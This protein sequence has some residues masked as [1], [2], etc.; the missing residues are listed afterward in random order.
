M[1]DPTISQR[2]LNRIHVL[3]NVIEGKVSLSEAAQVL[4]VSYRHAKRLKK[5]AADGGL[6]GILHGNRER[7]PANKTDPVMRER[8]I[9]LSDERYS[10]FNDSH[11]TEML[12]E[13]EGIVISRETVRVIRREAGIKPK[14]K[15]RARKHRKRRPR[16]AAEGMMMLW[17]GSPHAW[18]GKDCESCCLMAAMDDATGQALSLFFSEKESSW[19]YFKLLERIVSRYGIPGSVYQDRHSALVR[20]DDFMSLEEQFAGRQDPTQVGA[21]LLS[22]GIEPIVALSPQAKGRIERLFKTLQDRLV[23]CLE[24]EGIKDMGEANIYLEERFMDEYNARFQVEPEDVV[25]VWRKP[26]TNLDLARVLSFRYEATVGNDNA[27]RFSG[28][29]ID[30]PPGKWQR[31][32]AGVRVELRQLLDG[33]WRVYYKDQVIAEA[34]STEIAEPIRAKRRRKGV[35]AAHDSFWVYIGSAPVQVAERVLASR[36]PDPSSDGGSPAYQAAG[37]MRR[38]GPGRTIGATRIA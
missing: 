4:G 38:A 37:R 10:K 12:L 23:A 17:D 21:A 9:G 13:R 7:P 1:G 30:I 25:S 29:T 11:F 34:E 35:P 6:S 28:M 20:N 18:F 36:S 5:A 19:G 14:Q 26:A 8:I 31:S 27:V 32:Y 15:R 16:K 24:L 3:R 22:L 2:D 33:S